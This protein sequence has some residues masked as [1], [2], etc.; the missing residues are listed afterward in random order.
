MLVD[1]HKD[2]VEQKT[3]ASL[4]G[5]GK[6]GLKLYTTKE[7]FFSDIEKSCEDGTK[8]GK[9]NTEDVVSSALIG[10]VKTNS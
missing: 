9:D 2:C 3:P 6:A 4:I 7:D 8:E 1:W 10:I 5:N